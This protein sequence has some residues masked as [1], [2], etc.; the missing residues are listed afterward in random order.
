MPTDT[1][2]E[3]DIPRPALAGIACGV[4]ASLSIIWLNIL[5]DAQGHA[6]LVAA[7]ATP[8][9]AFALLDGSARSLFSEITATVVFVT[10]AFLI[11]DASAWA[12][13]AVLAAHGIW[14]IA[15]LKGRI[16]SHVGDYPVWCASLDLTAAGVLLA[17]TAL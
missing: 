13:A 5:P 15:H 8:Y 6:I 4:A 3:V 2:G 17:S 12:V 14:D 10:T 7:I 1:T 9:L 11:L 16:T